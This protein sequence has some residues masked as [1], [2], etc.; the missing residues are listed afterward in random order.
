VLAHPAF[1]GGAVTTRF[2]ELHPEV[3][4][5]RRDAQNRGE[6]LLRYLSSV[7]V[8]GP[9]PALGATGPPPLI[10]SPT[11]PRLPLPRSEVKV[12]PTGATSG[13]GSSG[14]RSGGPRLRDVFLKQGP[15]AFATAVRAHP[16]TLVM[17]TTWRD[18]HQSLLATRVRTQDLLA[19]APAT[20]EALASAYALEC[21]GGATFDVAM[22]FLVRGWRWCAVADERRG[23]GSYAPTAAS[24]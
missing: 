24:P 9:E 3:L 23:A 19:I 6:K 12:D 7:A 17:D 8:N 1:R 2:I 21:W 13:G 10:S 5:A 18:A 4:V 11:V 16:G 14:T 22:R 15:K 20:R